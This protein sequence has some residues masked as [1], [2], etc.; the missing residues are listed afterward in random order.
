MAFSEFASKL[1]TELP[2]GRTVITSAWNPNEIQTLHSLKK[3]LGIEQD[4]TCMKIAVKIADNVI[5]N[6]F[7]GLNL[8]VSLK[9]KRRND[10]KVGDS[11]V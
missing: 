7:V 1:G 9:R 4:S 8:K 10:A 3:A 11:Y 2:D 6:N 5:R